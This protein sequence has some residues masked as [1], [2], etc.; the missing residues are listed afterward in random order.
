MTGT[1]GLG[2][3]GEFVA[4][5]ASAAPV[6]GGGGAS[7]LTGAVGTA[8]CAMVG[9]LTVGKP[10]YAESEAEVR[11]LM[12]VCEAL[13]AALLRQIPADAEGFLPLSQAYGLPKDA[14]RRREIIDAAAVRACAAPLEIMHLCC[15]AIEAVARMAEIGAR[16]ALSDAGC[17]AVLVKAALEAASLNVSVNTRLMQDRAAAEKR[18]AA[19]R[20]MLARY[21]P[22]ADRVLAQVRERLRA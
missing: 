22:L 9:A 20:E 11:E 16:P 13:Q 6:P 12:A 15:R 4:A 14:P 3:C 1:E 18:D 5:L 2:A 10:R 17:A 8:L 21:G 19:C 7:A